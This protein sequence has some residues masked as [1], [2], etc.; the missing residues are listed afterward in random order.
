[1]K[2]LGACG[3]PIILIMREM[4]SLLV[5]SLITLDREPKSGRAKATA[6]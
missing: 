6:R 4:L 3:T 2:D 5:Q 1:L